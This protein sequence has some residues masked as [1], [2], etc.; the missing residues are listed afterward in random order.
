MVD[1]RALLEAIIETV[2]QLD[3]LRLRRALQRRGAAVVVVE[4]E[5]L[6]LREA[7]EV[8]I[9][10]VGM[11]LEIEVVVLEHGQTL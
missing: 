9:I 1:L 11:R 6:E 8:R 3:A 7:G 4:C 10:K 5:V 2:F